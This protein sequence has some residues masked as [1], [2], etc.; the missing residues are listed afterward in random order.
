MCTVDGICKMFTMVHL[1]KS[2]F[3]FSSLQTN[4]KAADIFEKLSSFFKSEHLERKNLA[5]CCTDA[6]SP[7]LSCN[8]GFQ[9]PVKQ[10]VLTSKSV[11]CMLHRQA[12]ASKTSPDSIQTVLEQMIQISNFIK[13]KALNSHAFKRLCN[14]MD[15][16]HL[17][18]LYHS[19]SQPFW[20]TD[21][22]PIS[23]SI[24]GLK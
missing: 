8:L 10:L 23:I 4:T 3:F 11:H 19:G 22:F 5:I 7:M 17:V 18:F 20:P 6:A 9:A 15:S 2:F 12:L 21:Y 16:D 24:C 1:R 14:N 13:A